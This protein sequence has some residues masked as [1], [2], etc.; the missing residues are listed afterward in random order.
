M[1]K[2]TEH[3]VKEALETIAKERND[4]W[5]LDVYCRLQSMSDL[6]AEE[7][8]YHSSCRATFSTYSANDNKTKTSV[9]IK[10]VSRNK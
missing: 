6:P 9:N 1:H 5:G 4:E 7:A 10:Q 2:I 3:S 8:G